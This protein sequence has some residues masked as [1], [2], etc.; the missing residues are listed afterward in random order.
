MGEKVNI[1][2]E[3]NFSSSHNLKKSSSSAYMLKKYCFLYHKWVFWEYFFLNSWRVVVV[4][5]KEEKYSYVDHINGL[6]IF[7][8][9]HTHEYVYTYLLCINIQFK[10]KFQIVKCFKKI[11]CI[12]IS[13]TRKTYA[14]IYIIVK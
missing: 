6:K 8:T 13:I 4:L 14:A 5:Y 7:F 1:R 3:I 2:V 10:F 9:L 12:C 11:L